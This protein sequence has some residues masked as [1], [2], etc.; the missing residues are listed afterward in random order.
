[1]PLTVYINSVTDQSQ[2][3]IEPSEFD[4][5]GVMKNQNYL[6]ISS[7]QFPS[8]VKFALKVRVSGTN[9]YDNQYIPS[10]FSVAFAI[11]SASGALKTSSPVLEE[12]IQEPSEELSGKI[13][14]ANLDRASKPY[15]LDI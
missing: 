3:Y 8:L 11:Y 14:S 9:H 10:Q 7:D 12:S 5:V 13:F 1:M 15:H 2:T 6:R 4:Y